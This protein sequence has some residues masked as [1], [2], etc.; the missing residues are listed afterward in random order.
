MQTRASRFRAARSRQDN[1]L[2]VDDEEKST[3]P[4]KK[5]R[6]GVPQIGLFGEPGCE[7]SLQEFWRKFRKC[8]GPDFPRVESEMSGIAAV[9]EV[10]DNCP[11]PPN[12]DPN[13]ATYKQW[14][15]TVYSV[16]KSKLEDHTK[17]ARMSQRERISC[18]AQYRLCTRAKSQLQIAVTH[19]L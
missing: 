5:R 15:R 6:E 19:Q 4:G 9:P 2:V 11:R 16:W 3:F 18:T 13:T 7:T 14:E 1:P 8:F 17:E 12:N 10:L